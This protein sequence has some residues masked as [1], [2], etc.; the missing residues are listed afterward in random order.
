[1]REVALERG[2]MVLTTVEGRGD[3]FGGGM[4]SASASKFMVWAPDTAA[5][6]VLAPVAFPHLYEQYP[7]ARRE[8]MLNPAKIPKMD[9]SF[10]FPKRLGE[11]EDDN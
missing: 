4:S 3:P 9:T 7:T 1:M 11:D 2:L 8:I 5:L 6:G 10:N